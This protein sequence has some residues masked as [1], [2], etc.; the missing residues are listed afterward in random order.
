MYLAYCLERV[1]GYS[2]GKKKQA[3][4][5]D[6]LSGG[7]GAEIRDQRSYSYEDRVPERK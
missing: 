4:S 7:D 3:G 2:S 1:L 5:S 6:S